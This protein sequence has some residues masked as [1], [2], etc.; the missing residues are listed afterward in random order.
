MNFH[1]FQT[2]VL[3]GEPVVLTLS[4]ANSIIKPEMTLQLV[5]QLPSGLLVS[6]EGG[7]G[8]E[9]S[10]QCVGIYKVATGENKDFLLNAVANQ[11]GSFNI[12]GRMEWYFGNDPDETHDGD[13]ETLRLEVVAPK[14]TPT[15]TP[16]PTATPEPTL[17][18]HVGQPTVNL[19][20][21]QTEVKLGDPVKLQLSL[22]NSIAKPEMTLKLILQV[23]S[24]WSMSGSG[25]TES[26]TGQCTATYQVA[27]GDQ[28]SIELEMQPN[29]AGSFVVAA[30][31]EWWFGDDPNTLDGDAVELPLTVLPL[32]TT[33][34]TQPAQPPQRSQPIPTSGGG[35]G[36]FSAGGSGSLMLPRSADPASCRPDGAPI[37]VPSQPATSGEG[38]TGSVGPAGA[39]NSYRASAVNTIRNTLPGEKGAFDRSG[40]RGNRAGAS[41]PVAPFRVGRRTPAVEFD[42]LGLAVDL[43]DR[44]LH[45]FPAVTAQYAGG[46]PGSTASAL[47]G[48]AD[49]AARQ[50]LLRR[51]H[52]AVLCVRQ[53]DLHDCNPGGYWHSRHLCVQRQRPGRQNHVALLAL[54][55]GRRNTSRV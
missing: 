51:R 38:S 42:G 43:G 18:P 27:S 32:A 10:V 55:Q 46:A 35:D 21:T 20:A 53:L 23:P 12:D 17:P 11:P 52:L 24:G 33:V 37:V 54:G 2:E 26:C 1:A 28:R 22:V 7:I 47:A 36:C 48:A 14:L 50:P 6:G 5:L 49:A 31:M 39:D 4:V 19:H 3:V 13:A 41:C 30:Q 8:E 44:A 45:S 40:L 9:C 34:P 16:T 25:F 15:P 29:Q